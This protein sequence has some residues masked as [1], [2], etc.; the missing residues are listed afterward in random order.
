M[1]MRFECFGVAFVGD[2]PDAQGFI[3]AGGDE[4][5]TARVKDEAAYPVVMAD[6]SR[7]KINNEINFL[8]ISTF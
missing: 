6:L 8:F 4:V 3:V 5:F 1:L 2:V 7:T